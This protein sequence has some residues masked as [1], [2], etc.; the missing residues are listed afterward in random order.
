[1]A[2]LAFGGAPPRPEDIASLAGTLPL[3]LAFYEQ[4]V[5]RADRLA[6]RQVDESSLVAAAGEAARRLRAAETVLAHATAQ[7]A[8][9]E[10]AVAAA[11][12]AW[13]AVLPEPLPAAARLDDVRAFAAARD[14]V[15]ERL[16][17]HAT[18]AAR[19]AALER[20]HAG[21][22]AALAA[23]LG[24]PPAPLASLLAEA[25]QR[26]AR[27]A[28]AEQGAHLAGRNTRA[29]APPG[30]GTA[31]G[32]GSGRGGAGGLAAGLGRG[33]A[34]AW[35]AGRGGAGGAEQVLHLL[36]DLGRELERKT[37]IDT[38]LADMHAAAARFDAAATALATRLKLAPPPDAGTG[39]LLSIVR[40]ARER[41]ADHSARQGS[42]NSLATQAEQAGRTLADLARTEDQRA[43]DLAAVLA[44]CGAEDLETAE[45]RLAAAAARA[46]AVARQAEA[47]RALLAEGDG[48]TP[49]QVRAEVA[50]SRPTPCC[51]RW[52]RRKPPPPPRRT[53]RRKPPPSSRDAVLNL[54]SA[55]MKPPMPTP[56]PPGLRRRPPPTACFAKR[57]PPGWPPPCSAA[58]WRR[59]RPR[60]DRTCWP[61]SAPGSAI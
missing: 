24:G 9:A 4:A 23:A 16:G 35:P 26:L 2:R 50:G 56:S 42:R 34:P 18:A 22:A 49:D 11:A 6:D 21:W 59:W 54:I 47:Q 28:Q 32:A 33:A 7:H 30:R 40:A 10:C 48:L 27:A 43:A 3:A 12:A 51:R 15:I 39:A 13:R 1:M 52:P 46:E 29:T 20:Q 53:R 60:A 8:A 25:S 57:W 31:G 58:P 61:A 19:A 55:A 41:L 37:D 38:R 44:A 17:A 36:D 5:A 45:R 14:R